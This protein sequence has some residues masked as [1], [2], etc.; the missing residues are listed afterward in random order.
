MKKSIWLTWFAVMMSFCFIACDE[1]SEVNEYANWRE[2]N[3]RFVDSIAAVA[4]ENAD[5]KWRIIKSYKLPAD[6]PNDLSATSDV[7]DYIYCHVEEVGTGTESPI[8]TDSV[9]TNYRAWLING[10]LVDQSFRG[11][12][13]PLK[14]V[15]TKF[16]MNAT[17][18]GWGTALH[19]MHLGDSWTVYI[20]YALGYGSIVSGS[21]PAYSTLKYWINLAGI[22]PLGTT[23]PAWK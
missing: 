14:A 3:Q 17:I 20:P 15:P 8:F 21:V 5:G 22:Y 6:N 12:F 2:R 13:D 10:E 4:E 1:T 19:H 23:V 16:A 9:R 11:E 18:T 7:N